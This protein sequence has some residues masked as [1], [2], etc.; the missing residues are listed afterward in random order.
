MAGRGGKDFRKEVREVGVAPLSANRLAEAGPEELCRMAREEDVVSILRGAA[1]RAE[2]ISG[3]VALED[4][5]TR[6][7]AATN[8]LPKEDPNLQRQPDVPYESKGL[9][10]G[11]RR[12]GRVQ[13]P[14]GEASGRL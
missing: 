9:G 8:P 4:F 3:S 5:D 2:P 13:G 6:G 11:R 7:E 10:S 1:Q 14:S 12:D